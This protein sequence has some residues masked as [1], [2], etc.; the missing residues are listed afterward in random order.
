MFLRGALVDCECSR[1][2]AGGFGVLDDGAE[3]AEG[4]GG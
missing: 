1:G 2:R 4:V 3:G